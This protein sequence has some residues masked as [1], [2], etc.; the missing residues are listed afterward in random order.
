MGVFK[1]EITKKIVYKAT[2]SSLKM[3]INKMERDMV[4]KAFSAYKK[5]AYLI[6]VW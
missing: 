3:P 5:V 2:D 6:R 4:V 1:Y